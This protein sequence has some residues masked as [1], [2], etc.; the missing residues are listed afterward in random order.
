MT[1]ALPFECQLNHEDYTNP[2]TYRQV[3]N[4]NEC[5]SNG[6]LFGLSCHVCSKKFEKQA[7]ENV[8]VP[9][10]KKGQAV[11]TCENCYI[12]KGCK[13]AVCEGCFMMKV[14]EATAG[15]KH[16]QPRKL[17]CHHQH[18]PE[19]TENAPLVDNGKHPSCSCL[20]ISLLFAHAAILK[21]L[22][23]SFFC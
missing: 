14:S 19:A 1:P 18:S 5:N 11:Y 23:V 20:G 15:D 17:R 3:L 12:R 22:F 16:Q 2:G 6:L 10:G 13:F 7:G 4:S 21:K 8:F 9:G